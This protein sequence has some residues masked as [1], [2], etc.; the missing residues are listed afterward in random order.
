[1]RIA[2]VGYSFAPAASS[3][4]SSANTSPAGDTQSAFKEIAADEIPATWPED[5]YDPAT[6]LNFST[7]KALGVYSIFISF[8]ANT[9]FT[10]IGVLLAV[11]L[12]SCYRCYT[13][14]GVYQVALVLGVIETV[15]HMIPNVG[16]F[17]SLPLAVAAI[18]LASR[19]VKDFN[20]DWSEGYKSLAR[21][22]ITIV[23]VRCV[24]S[25]LLYGAIAHFI[26]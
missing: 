22:A 4:A 8:G 17:V 25:W 7:E 12:F 10:A 16:F 5:P 2:C 23:A 19:F 3:L 24:F 1:M 14:K 26:I 15:V 9:L 18:G 20:I 13:L 21:G 11:M 6:A